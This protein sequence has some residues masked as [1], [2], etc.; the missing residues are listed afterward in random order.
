M[1]SAP[2]PDAPG[3]PA[4]PVLVRRRQ[5]ARFAELGQRAGYGLYGLALGLFFLAMALDLPEGVVN[6]IVVALIL[7]SVVLAPA[8]VVGYGVKAAD[9]EDRERGIKG[10]K[11]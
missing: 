7:G 11:P 5:W 6:V 1:S 3:A 2:P 9:R 10:S 8:I 4:D